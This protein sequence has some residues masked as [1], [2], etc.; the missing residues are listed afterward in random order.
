M[1]RKQWQTRATINANAA[2]I[3][4]IRKFSE[5]DLE[6]FG[7]LAKELARDL[8]PVKT[9]DLKASIEAV[10]KGS[11]RLVFRT[12]TNYGGYV[13]FGTKRMPAR[14]YMAPAVHAALAE[15]KGIVEGHG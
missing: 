4:Q 11:M 2:A 3:R 9:G 6:A 12:R 13:E 14:P 8:V 15:M 10:K 1:A 7:D 5:E